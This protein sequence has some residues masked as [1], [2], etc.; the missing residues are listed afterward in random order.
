MDKIFTA[1]CGLCCA[2]CIPSNEAFF[3]LIRSLD[4]MLGKTQFEEYAR[5]KSE[6]NP[7]FKEYLVFLK[8]LREIKS[9]QCTSP[10]RNGGGKSG[11]EVRNCAQNKGYD[12]CW[13]CDGRRTCSLLD[14]LRRVHP[15][16]DYHLELIKQYGP[17]EWFQK[18]RAHYRWQQDKTAK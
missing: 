8:V 13:E 3:S 4:D 17:E 15:N 7:I 6:K 10:C 2:D 14:P 5:L 1:W 18:R 9:L 11:C 12:G 16:I